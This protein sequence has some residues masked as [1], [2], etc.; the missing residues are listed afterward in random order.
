M[1]AHRES[2]E[3]RAFLKNEFARTV[4]DFHSNNILQVYPRIGAQP[5]SRMAQMTEAFKEGINNRANFESYLFKLFKTDESFVNFLKL[6]DEEFAVMLGTTESSTEQL[7]ELYS[8]SDNSEQEILTNTTN[9]A[10]TR[11]Q[12]LMQDLECFLCEYVR[13]YWEAIVDATSR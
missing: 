11:E 1:I 4:C 7:M 5:R 13:L 6:Q 8:V 12:L 10:A 2:V 3:I 9:L